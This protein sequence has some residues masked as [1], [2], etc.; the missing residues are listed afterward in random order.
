MEATQIFYILSVFVV[1]READQNQ[2]NPSA[3]NSSFF[4]VF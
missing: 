3:C 1:D 2:T 4:S